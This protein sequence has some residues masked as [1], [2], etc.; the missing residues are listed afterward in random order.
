MAAPLSFL[1]LYFDIHTCIARFLSDREI[2]KTIALVSRDISRIY[3]SDFIWLPRVIMR[4]GLIPEA[5][6]I[7]KRF[8]EDAG[9]AYHAALVQAKQ[10]WWVSLLP[11]IVLGMSCICSTWYRGRWFCVRRREHV[12]E[13]VEQRKRLPYL[14]PQ[15]TI[16]SKICLYF[17]SATPACQVFVWDGR[18]YTVPGTVYLASPSSHEFLVAELLAF[19]VGEITKV[20]E[21]DVVARARFSRDV[22]DLA[23]ADNLNVVES[24]FV[25]SKDKFYSD[26]NLVIVRICPNPNLYSNAGHFLCIT[27]AT[28]AESHAEPWTT[29]GRICTSSKHRMQTVNATTHMSEDG[30]TRLV[31]VGAFCEVPTRPAGEY[32]RLDVP[33]VYATELTI[34]VRE[35][36]IGSGRLFVAW[37]DDDRTQ[38]TLPEITK[39]LTGGNGYG[40]SITSPL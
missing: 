29:I 32:W 8:E 9:V 4:P 13:F 20:P 23:I 27:F 34:R 18:I 22:L 19:G 10:C 38:P 1:G 16:S 21:N 14:P 3:R 39:A 36:P 24:Y 26:G 31:M 11:Q 30:V 25:I 37:E 15:D 40:L 2:C 5:R 28:K 12:L 7:A 6:D 17:K 35:G 33:D